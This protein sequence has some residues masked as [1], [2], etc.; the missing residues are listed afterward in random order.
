MT[1][2][3]MLLLIVSTIQ[4]LTLLSILFAVIWAIWKISVGTMEVM[5]TRKE[6]VA[7]AI[8]AEVAAQVAANR[9]EMVT[10]EVRAQSENISKIERSTNSMK[11]ALVAAT[12]ET[13]E[14]IG[15]RRGRENEIARRSAEINLNPEKEP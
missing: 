6:I 8:R 12:R 10:M 3:L 4:V 9:S 5:E 14:L 2:E 11:D 7:T 1:N 13:G 15:E